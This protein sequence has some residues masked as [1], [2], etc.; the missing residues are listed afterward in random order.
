[1]E[2]FKIGINNDAKLVVDTIKD[3]KPR[4]NLIIHSDHGAQYSS[5]QQIQLSKKHKFKISM[6]RVSN[7]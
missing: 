7:P 6:G 1:M 2:S 3:I 4:D 5:Y